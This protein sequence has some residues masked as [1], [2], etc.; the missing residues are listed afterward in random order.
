MQHP[1]HL[2]CSCGA[3]TWHIPAKAEGTRLICHCTDCAAYARHLGREDYLDNGG[4]ELFQ[5]LPDDIVFDTGKEHLEMLRLSQSGLYRWYAGC[6]NTP[7]ANTLPRNLPFAG[8]ILPKGR[9]DFGRLKCVFKGDQAPAPVRERGVAPAVFKIFKRMVLAL[10][11]GRRASP[12]WT[13]A[14]TPAAQPQIL[15]Q[16]QL[17]AARQ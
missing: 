8:A 9:T 12:F 13:D 5:C 3:M 10:A 1:R 7:I 16:D 17:K 11:S 2:S 6:C 14:K 15:T 4:T